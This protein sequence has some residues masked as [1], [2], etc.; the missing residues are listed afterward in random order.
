MDKTQLYGSDLSHNDDTY[1][2]KTPAG[3]VYKISSRRWE[4]FSAEYNRREKD[5][6]TAR[7]LC[8]LLGFLGVH[9]YYVGDYLKGFLLLGTFGGF[10]F[11]W[12]LDYLFIQARVD[13]YNRDLMLDLIAQAIE[14]TRK[15]EE[16]EERKKE[17]SD[18][19]NKKPLQR[20]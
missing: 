9:R 10:L 19:I 2:I 17:N 18:G 12:L 15:D 3:E 8:V 4:K 16:E 14:A 1:T 13:E 6:K 20:A 5:K 11:G 7:W